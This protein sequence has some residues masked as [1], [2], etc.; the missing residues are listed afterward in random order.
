[1]DAQRQAFLDDIEADLTTTTSN[2][3]AGAGPRPV[4]AGHSSRFIRRVA[5]VGVALAA[6]V[7]FAML[8]T[9]AA[10]ASTA[11]S[12][13]PAVDCFTPRPV[14]AN[15]T[16]GCNS[17]AFVNFKFDFSYA[18]GPG[19]QRDCFVFERTYFSPC[20]GAVD[21]PAATACN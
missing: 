12:V 18:A 6:G 14:A 8:S 21:L 4:T 10:H 2:H 15:Y 5:A 3:L 16:K 17:G 7:P 13:H 9:T 11:G 1:M 19:G 20:T